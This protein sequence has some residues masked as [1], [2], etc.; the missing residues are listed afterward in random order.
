MVGATLST[1][2]IGAGEEL[3]RALD[4]AGVRVTAALWYFDEDA[5]RWKLLLASPQVAARGPRE[6]YG[7]IQAVMNDPRASSTVESVI[8]LSDVNVLPADDPL[9]DLLR[10]SLG[11]LRGIHRVRFTNNV[12]NGHVIADALIYRLAA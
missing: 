12:V 7:R 9:V 5:Q 11:E 8:D 1:E 4:D 10:G 2:Q 6:L 3:V